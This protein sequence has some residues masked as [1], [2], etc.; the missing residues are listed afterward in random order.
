RRR[1][2]LMRP[3]RSLLGVALVTLTT[4]AHAQTGK[5]AFDRT[6]VP[7]ARP[8][9]TVKLPTWTKATLSNGAQLVVVERHSLPL[10]S[11]TMNFIGGPYQ[12]EAADKPGVG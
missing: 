7:K 9:P 1:G 2:S 6:I 3:I 4:A 10:I 5:S 11:F 12:F 8:D